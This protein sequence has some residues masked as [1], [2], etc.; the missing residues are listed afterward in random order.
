M[1]IKKYITRKFRIIF[2]FLIVVACVGILTSSLT[3]ATVYKYI[4][5]E[6]I[7]GF[8][9]AKEFPDYV[10]AIT[11]FAIWTVGIAALFMISWGGFV[12]MTSAGNTSRVETGKRI[13]YDAF[14][15]LIIALAAWLILYVINPDLVRVGVSLVP[16]PTYIT[17]KMIEY[18]AKTYSQTG[19]YPKI[20]ATMPKN[21]ND[22][23]W[24]KIFKDVADSKNID[25]CILQATAAIESGCNQHPKRTYGGR[26]C[27]VM[28]VR[29]QDH[30][31]TTCDDLEKNP[32]KA[33]E[34]AANVLNSCSNLWRR[35]PTDLWIRDYYA[36][37]NGGC[38]TLAK[39]KDCPDTMLNSYNKPY[40]K[41]DCP[42]DC[43]GYCP[44]PARTSVFLE[45]YKQCKAAN[46]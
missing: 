24:Q 37:Y 29:A 3:H 31:Q 2:L 23:S 18:S 4:P 14:Y 16:V 10:L 15:G 32:Q 12:Y 17:D 33:V 38:G 22:P 13:I 6:S 43:G 45:Y 19:Q 21:C 34:C 36:G 11:K 26:D 27:S 8:E 42:I 1:K 20:P 7:P 40:L 30:C 46:P 35:E 44:V 39:S 41:W 28:Q 9:G 25:K 5:L